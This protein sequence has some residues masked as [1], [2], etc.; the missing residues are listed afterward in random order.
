M[1]FDITSGLVRSGHGTAALVDSGHNFGK[2][3][4]R[5]QRQQKPASPDNISQP[6]GEILVRTCTVHAPELVMKRKCQSCHVHFQM[7]LHVW[8]KPQ[9]F[10]FVGQLLPGTTTLVLASLH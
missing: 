7:W 3:K 10:A 5:I 6:G 1:V 4:R 9:E 8:R 2:L